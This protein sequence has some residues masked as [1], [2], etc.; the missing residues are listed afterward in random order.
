MFF[1]LSFRLFLAALCPI[2][3]V[4]SN[5]NPIFFLTSPPLSSIVGVFINPPS[6][7]KSNR[8][9][10]FG[11]RSQTKNYNGMRC[12]PHCSFTAMWYYYYY[13]LFEV[14]D[15]RVLSTN[16]NG[17]GVACLCWS[18]FDIKLYRW[19]VIYFSWIWRKPRAKVMLWKLWARRWQ[20][21]PKVYRTIHVCV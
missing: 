4:Q 20:G 15:M 6:Q 5:R 2:R 10:C 13:L 3:L 7:H 19:I 12:L 8:N 1:L 21:S 9:H 16:N 11:P 18:L 14:K 17:A